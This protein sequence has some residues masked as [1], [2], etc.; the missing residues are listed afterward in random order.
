MAIM[1]QIFA[2][3]K[4]DTATRQKVDQTAE[5]TDVVH[6]MLNS[7]LEEYKKVLDAKATE[8]LEKAMAIAKAERDSAVAEL[9]KEIAS[10]KASAT[11][12]AETKAAL[13]IV[14]AQNATS[15]NDRELLRQHQIELHAA[16]EKIAAAAGLAALK[17]T[18][19]AG[20][21]ATK[22]T[23]VAKDVANELKAN[24]P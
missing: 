24:K 12:A 13:E 17:V 3:Q 1:Y 19:V 6:S 21:A 7:H 18:D 5:R 22:I 20:V 14:Q 23:D 4:R 11:A 16:I 9:Q 2:S 10:L 15:I 8:T